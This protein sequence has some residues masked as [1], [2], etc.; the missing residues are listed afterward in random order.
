MLCIGRSRGA[1]SEEPEPTILA[2]TFRKALALT[3][4]SRMT[5]EC[6]DGIIKLQRGHDRTEKWKRASVCYNSLIAICETI[7]N[8]DVPY[9]CVILDE[10]G[11]S[12]RHFCQD[13]MSSVA[14]DCLERLRKILSKAKTVIVM[15]YKLTERDVAFYTE[16]CGL[17]LYDPNIYSVR[18]RYIDRPPQK[19]YY[20]M[21]KTTAK[22]ALMK[23]LKDQGGDRNPVMVTCTSVGKLIRSLIV[24]YQSHY[25]VDSF[26]LFCLFHAQNFLLPWL[27]I[28]RSLHWTMSLEMSILR[29]SCW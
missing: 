28:F 17:D 6:Y 15:Q 3:L 26:C 22:L 21:E 10:A 18:F 1:L 19:I 16:L 20:T 2:P 13:I 27:P 25:S 8:S 7:M 4:S 12:R 9:D 5:L 14:A 23:Y 24:H 11:M 29:K